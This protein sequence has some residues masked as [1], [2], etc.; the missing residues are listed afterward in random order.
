MVLLAGALLLIL[1]SFPLIRLAFGHR[2]APSYLA[3]VLL[4]PG[5]V[6]MGLARVLGADIAGR[7]FPRYGA[8]AAWIT[9]VV[10]VLLDLLLIPRALALPGLPALY[11]LGWGINGAAV[12]SSAAYTVSL[13]V[14][15]IAYRRLTGIALR[16]L[17]L[18]RLAEFA[19]LTGR[20]RSLAGRRQP[21][22][23]R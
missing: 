2:F 13:L 12:A 4:L 3:M 11:G 8:L 23:A 21:G 6:A 7:G 14:L 15:T 22:A 16:D 1:A 18:P 10:T 19:E 5:M 20:L 9:L 17:F